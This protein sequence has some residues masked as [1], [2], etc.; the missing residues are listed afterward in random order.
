M[1][2]P[3]VPAIRVRGP[4]R[5]PEEILLRQDSGFAARGWNDGRKQERRE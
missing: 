2:P 1:L 5:N 3:V 4:I